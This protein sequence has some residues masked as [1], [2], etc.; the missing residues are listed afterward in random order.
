[1]DLEAWP[2]T[3]DEI[4]AIAPERVGVTHFGLHDDAA[5]RVEQMRAR[6]RELTIRVMAAVDR[7]DED[8]AARYNDE[9]RHHLSQH[10]DA[11]R[12]GRYFDCF[13]AESDWAGVA[14]Y[15]KRNP[16]P[17]WID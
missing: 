13:G 3:L 11:E 14:F 8:D 10:V 5:D 16:A 9:V 4:L 1:M 7:G 17:S 15:L 2:Q 12:V 6:L